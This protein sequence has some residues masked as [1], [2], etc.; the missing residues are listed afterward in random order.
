MDAWRSQRKNWPLTPGNHGMGD[1]SRDVYITPDGPRPGLRG[2]PLADFFRQTKSKTV[3]VPTNPNEW[4]KYCPFPPQEELTADVARVQAFKV[5]ADAES[6]LQSS[7][8]WYCQPLAR[9]RIAQSKVSREMLLQDPENFPAD[10]QLCNLID[11]RSGKQRMLLFDAKTGLV[12]SAGEHDVPQDPTWIP[13]RS[14]LHNLKK[15]AARDVPSEV[16][17]GVECDDARAAL[18][19]REQM[20]AEREVLVICCGP[21]ASCINTNEIVS[22]LMLLLEKGIRIAVVVNQTLMKKDIA[23]TAFLI[24]ARHT[25]RMTVEV[26]PEEFPSQLLCL[27]TKLKIATEDMIEDLDRV[28]PHGGNEP[29]WPKPL[30]REKMTLDGQCHAAHKSKRVGSISVCIGVPSSTVEWFDY[31]M[32]RSMSL[33]NWLRTVRDARDADVAREQRFSLSLLPGNRM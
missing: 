8:R 33:D 29:I 1:E 20:L 21:H 22:V 2:S 19:A 5:K 16:V 3:Y 12:R 30:F 23:L 15:Y 7:E 11:V 17:T 27:S 26:T 9:L 10:D 4:V 13:G 31:I 28:G 25:L 24:K 18:I 32:L 14:G 6:D